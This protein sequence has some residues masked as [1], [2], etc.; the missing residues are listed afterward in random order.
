MSQLKRDLGTLREALPYIQ[1]FHGSTFVIRL[2]G[3]ALSTSELTQ[4]FAEDIALLKH[5]GVH[6]VVVHGGVA[7]MTEFS[8]EAEIVER[9][10]AA[11]DASAADEAAAR[12]MVLVGL[13]NKQLVQQIGNAGVR[14]IGLSG[15][16]ANMFEIGPRARSDELTRAVLQV[17]TG[18]VDRVREH[19][20][21]VVAAVG[22][23]G[24]QARGEIRS[25]FAAASLAAA[26]GA[27]KLILMTDRV[28][29]CTTPDDVSSRVSETTTTEV[30]RHIGDTETTD[31]DTAALLDASVQA[32]D[33]G[34]GYAHIID[35]RD[36]AALLLELFSVDGVGTKIWPDIP[37]APRRW[38]DE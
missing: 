11:P 14:A 9:F 29:W 12:V 24:D 32:I 31:P 30:R 18:V 25:E 22:V 10:A 28:G 37:E 23:A 21:P 6:P 20:V 5:V 27:E 2:G 7:D 38:G 33:Q 3:L 34:A 8:H 4:R 26:L 19:Y 17:N 16:D 15:L 1:A 36:P 35:S 13:I